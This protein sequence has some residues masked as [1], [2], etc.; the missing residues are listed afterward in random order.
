MTVVHNII[1]ECRTPADGVRTCALKMSGGHVVAIVPCSIIPC[2]R[3][4][5][6][7][8]NRV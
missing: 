3:V 4:P 8:A 2:I 7:G 1:A 6:L 5:C